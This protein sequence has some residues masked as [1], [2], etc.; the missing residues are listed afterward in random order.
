MKHTPRET[1]LLKD[2]CTIKTGKRDANHGNPQGAYPFFTCADEIFKIDEF[3]FD[4]DAILIA[5]NGNFNIKHFSGKFDAYQR[6]Y[7][8]QNFNINY[9]F[10]YYYLVA[11]LKDLTK[12][13][14][15]STVQYIRLANLTEYPVPVFNADEQERIVAKIEEL[16]SE[17]DKSV[18]SL[19]TEF[20]HCSLLRTS[21]IQHAYQNNDS[22]DIELSNVTEIITDGD[23]QAPPKSASGIPFIVISNIINNRVILERVSRYVPESYYLNLK[24]SRKAKAG[25]ILYTVTGSYGI[26]ALIEN[27][28]KFC[29]QRHIALL[30]PDKLKI[31]SKYLLYALQTDSVCKQATKIATGTAQLTV[32]LT[33]LRRITIP[34]VDMEK[35]RIIVETVEA[36]LSEL[37]L[38]KKTIEES[39]MQATH[40]KQSILSKAFKGELI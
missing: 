6:T 28:D 8:L 38:L 11:N 23:H 13:H 22:R 7:V 33:G 34:I 15:G 17:I 2:Y 1:V 10:L 16:L 32:P 9:K 40:M 31:S 35:Q 19:E 24:D 18:R 36:Q 30:R 5:G 26:P 25:D 21:I 4:G 39:I 29:F 20:A 3:N 27:N 37:D 12:G 14:R